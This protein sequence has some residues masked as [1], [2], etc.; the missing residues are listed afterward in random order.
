MTVEAKSVGVKM[1]TWELKVSW[2]PLCSDSS[3]DPDKATNKDRAVI[4]RKPR[5]QAQGRR[6][7]KGSQ[8]GLLQMFLKEDA[9]LEEGGVCKYLVPVSSG[10]WCL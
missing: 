4:S 3:T 1:K 2:W 5:R 7:L 6:R 8:Q 9:M 10:V